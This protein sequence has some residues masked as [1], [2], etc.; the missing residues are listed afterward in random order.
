[1]RQRIRSRGHVQRLPELFPLLRVLLDRDP[2]PARFLVLGSASPDV[3]RGVSE[4]LAGR[5][6]FVMMGGFRSAEV[7]YPA[8]RELWLRGTF[9]RS[10]LAA[11]L[12]DSRVWRRD[13]VET[14]VFI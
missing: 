10:F 6:E 11:T 14:F 12:D 2:L 7:G 9:P 1:M 5:I 13:F 8:Q 3:V 4:T